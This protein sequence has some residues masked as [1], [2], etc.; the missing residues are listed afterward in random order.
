VKYG[1]VVFF[2][3]GEMGYVFSMSPDRCEI[4]TF[5]DSPIHSGCQVSRSG[6][7]LT[8]PVGEELLGR[9]VDVL[10]R[11]ID[12]EYFKTPVERR[13]VERLSPGI[14]KR[15]KI[16]EPL[17]TGVSVVDMLIPLGKGQRE[18]VIG[19]RQT[20][21]TEFLL[22]TM[23]TQVKKG[24]VCVYANIGKRKYDIKRVEDFVAHNNILEGVT[25]ISSSSTDPLLAIFVTPYTAMTL[26]EYYLD[27]GKDVLLILDDLSTH[28]KF[29]REISLIG[30]RFPGRNSYPGDIFYSHSR[31][32]ERSGNFVTE[33]G[34]RAITCLAAAETIEND[35]SGYI[36]TNL[37]SITDGHIYFDH[38]L[39]EQG[40]RP[41]VNYFLSVTRVGRQTQNKVGWGV[42]REL[43]S[44]LSLYEKTQRFIHFGA[45]INEGIRSTLSMGGKILN[46]FDQPMG[47]VIDMR[48]QTFLFCL[49]WTGAI[50]DDSPSRLKYIR[51]RGISLYKSDKNFSDEVNS[52]VETSSDFNVLLGKISSRTKEFMG[53]LD[54]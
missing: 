36:Q 51:E 46:F 47:N 5:A 17:E 43:S 7:L 50:S 22:Q 20:G 30:K 44:F 3:S 13:P 31:L 49:I 54:R 32:L 34:P 48:I 15:V 2:E 19:D 33:N 41:A 12:H 52:L 27:R 35:I 40:R 6:E 10:F 4:L 38:E 1:E 16:N 39:F 11:S 29:Y 25:I 14:E 18:L 21:K 8:I 9:H 23:L 42:N 53:A 26:A 24:A 37:M 45:E 28:A